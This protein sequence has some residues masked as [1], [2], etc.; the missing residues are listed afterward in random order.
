MKLHWKLVLFM[1][2]PLTYHVRLL[3]FCFKLQLIPVLIV[4]E[5]G[6]DNGMIQ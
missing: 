2:L 3:A 4:V 6:F 5:L 1:L